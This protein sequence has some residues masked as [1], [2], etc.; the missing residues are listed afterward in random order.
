MNRLSPL[1]IEIIRLDFLCSNSPREKSSGLPASH[2]SG[3]MKYLGEFI[4]VGGDSDD[5]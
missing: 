5:L 1:G 2:P 3:T 4:F